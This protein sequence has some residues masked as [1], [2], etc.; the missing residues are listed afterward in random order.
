M[1]KKRATKRNKTYFFCIFPPR[2]VSDAS[3][4]TMDDDY[5][6]DMLRCN[7]ILI[8][9]FADVRCDIDP[10]KEIISVVLYLFSSQ[11]QQK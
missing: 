3:L 5:N 2:H 6:D 10:T 1:G 7:R 8:V 9:S 11:L 4:C